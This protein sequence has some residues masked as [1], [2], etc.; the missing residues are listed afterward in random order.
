LV[1]YPNGHY[2]LR[3]Y[4]QSRPKY[5]TLALN[6]PV[7]AVHALE[8]ARRVAKASAVDSRNPLTLLTTAAPFYIRDCERRQKPE[9]AIQAKKTL[10]EFLPLCPVSHVRSIT[11]E[12]VLKYHATL[13]SKGLKE[14]TIANKHTRV[15]SFLRF[16]KVD[17]SFM[18]GIAPTYEDTLPTI[19]DP[20]QVKAI[21]EAA[22]PY[23]RLVV[24]MALK[25][26]LREQELLFSEWSDVDWNQ[27]VYRVQ[28]KPSRG[29]A[30]KD[31]QQ[32]DVPIPADLLT[33]LSQWHKTNPKSALIIG[34][35]SDKPN[36][37]LLRT[38][39]RLAKRTGL[40]CGKCDGCKGKLG[41]CSEWTLHEFRRTYIT[42]LLRSGL[43]LKTV[44]HY[45]GHS[46]LASTMRYLRPASTSETQDRINAIKWE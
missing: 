18:K 20:S 29:F 32:R 39:K 35:A 21:R 14:R 3:T 44:Q 25:L 24:D 7:V 22:D 13:R 8:K 5:E 1:E 26:G 10:D 15:K 40:N 33:I 37:H 19:Y 34:T 28:G 23:M 17:T 6:H 12:M 42:T 43:D 45:A 11:R 38:L 16:C 41:E 31:K 9:A 36:K 30:V 4:V 27:S 46:D 2:Q